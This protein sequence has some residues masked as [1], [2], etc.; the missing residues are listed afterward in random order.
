MSDAVRVAM[1]KTSAEDTLIVVTADH[2]HTLTIS[3]YPKRGNP[4]LGKVVG[5]DWYTGGG[6]AP[7]LDA[8]GL[9]YTTLSYANGPGYTGASGQQPEGAHTWG[10]RPCD[11]SSPG[12]SF[13]GIHEGRPDLSEIDTEAPTFLQ[14]ATVPMRSETH[15][16]EDVPIYAG[17]ARAALF[18]GV[19][20][21]S[22]IYH[23]MVE[24]LGWTRGGVPTN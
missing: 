24:A 13:E 23:A 3:G 22:Y 17:G 9:P 16:G 14:E 1:E 8:M 19:R 12:C 20:E 4:I 15:A 11:Q 5:V 7:G 21:Q 10:H 18:H 2:S 6:D